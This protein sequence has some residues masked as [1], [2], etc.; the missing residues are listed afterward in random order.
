MDRREFS[1]TLDKSALT[2]EELASRLS[3]TIEAGFV[4]Q[5]NTDK[6]AAWQIMHGVLCY[7]DKLQIRDEHG[8]T[9]QATDYLLNGGLVDGFEL[10][11]GDDLLPVTQNLGVRARLEPGSYTGQGH[12]DQWIAVLAMAGIPAD[13]KVKIGTSEKLVSDWARQAQYDVTRNP[14]DEFGWTLIALTY[15]LPEEPSW[16][17]QGDARVTWEDLVAVEV[18]QDLNMAACGGTHRLCGIVHALQQKK[19]LK[20][21]DSAVWQRA[22]ELVE[23]CKAE[24][25]EFRAPDGALSCNYFVRPGTSKDLST[26]L[27]SAGHLFEFYALAATDDELKEPWV[28][29]AANHICDLLDAAQAVD[30]ECGALYHAIHGLKIY[31]QRRFESDD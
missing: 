6:N 19:R 8:G 5:L 16:I 27:A 9:T 20:L 10:Q 17:A 15:Y 30:L 2:P 31:H 12:V 22:D 1:S 7:G 28:E 13:R 21:S 26:E 3:Q 11:L 23:K 14:L 25:R 4:R 24:V 29:V 18:D